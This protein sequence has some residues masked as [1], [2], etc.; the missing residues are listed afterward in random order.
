[1]A[2][3]NSQRGRG[4]IRKSTNSSNR[5]SKISKPGGNGR[6]FIKKRGGEANQRGRGGGRQVRPSKDEDFE[7]VRR[8]PTPE[9]DIE[10]SEQS[11]SESGS[12]SDSDSPQ[13]EPNIQRQQRQ[14]APKQHLSKAQRKAQRKPKNFI[15]SPS[16][17]L[18]IAETAAESQEN[19]LEG[20]LTK[21]E[22][23]KA[24][25]AK[26]D[27]KEQ[28]K[29]AQKEG[30]VKNVIEKLKEKEREKK[31]ARKMKLKGHAVEG[32]GTPKT[33]PSEGFRTAPTTPGPASAPGTGG[34]GVEKKQKKEKK[35]VSFSKARIMT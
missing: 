11:D 19:R 27:E 7:T 16:A 30:K 4:P 25:L 29:L 32:R 8:E 15:T 34:A 9:S 26:R 14:T 20:K 13:Q 33:A 22:S 12:D 18:A 3:K 23:K 10:S 2:P 5:D 1:M 24:W 17:L 28:R 35:R 31:K 6:E 21:L